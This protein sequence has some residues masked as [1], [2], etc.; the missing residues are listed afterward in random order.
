M[1]Q[2]DISIRSAIVALL[3]LGA[4]LIGLPSLAN[5]AP[6]AREQVV[7]LIPL[8]RSNAPLCAGAPS[9][10]KCE[11]GDMTLFSGLLC[12]SGEAIGCASVKAAQGADG[13][14]HRSP[15]LKQNPALRPTNSFS[16]DMALG[17]QLYAATTSDKVALEHWLQWVEAA[18]P[19]LTESPALNGKTYCLVRGWPRWCP[20]DDEKG[21]TARPQD[22]ATLIVTIDKLGVKIPSPAETKLPGGAADLV[23]APLI[24]ASREANAAFSL[25][26]LL[27][28]ARGLQPTIVLL[29]S[30]GNRPGYSRH[31][32]GV[33]V[34]LL[35]RLGAGSE[36]VD[37]AAAILIGHEPD[38]PFFKY[39]AGKSADDISGRLL[40]VGPNDAASLPSDKADWAWQ[41]ET[42]EE[43]WKKSNL[44]DFVFM[45]NLVGSMP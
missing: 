16:W 40:A 13:R 18:R 28:L 17:V 4:G 44:W 45:G 36:T 9:S 38:N 11:D 27:P 43:A 6:T 3:F 34:L 1:T 12:A 37:R 35:R 5:A 22:L 30:A 25:E 33:E 31:L 24:A 21:C 8:W 29:D 7:A 2:P 39:L 20:D 26:K 42:K 14:W 10:D 32:A 15:R 23:L 41:R 19:C